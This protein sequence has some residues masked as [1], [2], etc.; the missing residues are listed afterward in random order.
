[1]SMLRIHFADGTTERTA[2]DLADALR[3]LAETYG[4]DLYFGDWDTYGADGA[5]R[6]LIWST[7]ANAND[8]F[9]GSK[10]FAEIIRP[11]SVVAAT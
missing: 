2:C 6:Q 7:E 5:E 10:A 3:I 9:D 1:M 11:R 4:P 8:D